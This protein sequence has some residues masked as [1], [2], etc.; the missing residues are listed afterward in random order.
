MLLHWDGKRSTYGGS[1]L[2]ADALLKAWVPLLI[3]CLEDPCVD[4][5]RV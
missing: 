3:L 4:G 1:A 5:S 2:W